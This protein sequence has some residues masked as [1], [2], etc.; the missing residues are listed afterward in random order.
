VADDENPSCVNDERL[1]KSVFPNRSRHLIYGGLGNEP[2]VLL[3]GKRTLRLPPLY[4]EGA[5]KRF[6]ALLR[7]RLI[8]W[9]CVFHPDLPSKD[10]A[11][12]WT[13]SNFA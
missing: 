12:G 13:A 6:P 3:I 1:A 5:F 9:T 4:R 11:M 2:G 8:Y 7:S 10:P